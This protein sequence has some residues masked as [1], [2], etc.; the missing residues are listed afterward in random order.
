[1]SDHEKAFG[2]FP[3]GLKGEYFLIDVF[4]IEAIGQTDDARMA[5]IFCES[6]KFYRSNVELEELPE[7]VADAASNA[8]NIIAEVATMA[9]RGGRPYDDEPPMNDEDDTFGK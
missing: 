8:L 7:G 5:I 2:K 4:T 1:V 9:A 6:G 3:G